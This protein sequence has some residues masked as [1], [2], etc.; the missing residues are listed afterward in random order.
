MIMCNTPM[1]WGCSK[2]NDIW[3]KVITT[4]LTK[5]ATTTRYTR[6]NGNTIT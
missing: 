1:N 5:I 3:A 4:S 6:F 2:K